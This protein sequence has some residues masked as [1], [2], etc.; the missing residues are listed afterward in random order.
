M[1][2]S[3]SELKSKCKS[4]IYPLLPFFH[5]KRIVLGC[6]FVLLLLVLSAILSI[7]HQRQEHILHYEQNIEVLSFKE[8]LFVAVDDALLDTAIQAGKCQKL[9][10]SIDGNIAAFLTDSKELYM[11]NG[12]NLR[13]IADDVL[14]F[15]ISSSGEGIAFAQ[16]YV[17]Q[18]ALTLYD[19]AE[20]TRK[21][22]TTLLSRLDFA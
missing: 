8:K 3:L 5:Y 7:A 13:K 12:R 14:H 21:E 22:I 17:K 10:T 6:S 19:L 9:S 1:K 11:V 2:Q 18:N 4:S 15:E 16:K 20:E